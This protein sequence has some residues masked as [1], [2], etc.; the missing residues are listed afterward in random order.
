MKREQDKDISI[1]GLSLEQLA[2]L[3][4]EGDKQHDTNA[5]LHLKIKPMLKMK[6][7]LRAGSGPIGLGRA[8]E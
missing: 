5:G 4:Y 2:V 7:G 6:T 3:D 1:D 8:A